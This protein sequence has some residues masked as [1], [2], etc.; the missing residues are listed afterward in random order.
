LRA[1]CKN[2]ELKFKSMN[3]KNYEINDKSDCFVI[4]EIG[5]NHQ[6]N[7]EVC[8]KMFKAAKECGVDA[9]KLQKRDNRFL[10]TK[11]FYDSAYSSENAYGPTYGLHREALEFGEAEYQELKKYA[12]ELGLIFF[13]TAFDFRSADFLAEMDMPCFKIASGDLTNIPLLKYVASFGKPMIIS[14][15]AATMEDVERAYNAI[16]LT[17][18][19]I[20]LLQCTATYPTDPAYLDLAVINTYKNKFP[21]TV[22]GLSDHYN[23]I[24]LGLVA[25]TLGARI[26]E[27]HFT[28]D[29][30][31]RGTDHA[32]SLEPVG[33]KKL[34]RDLKRARL[35]MGDGNKKIYEEERSARKKMG[36]K[37][38]VARNLPEGHV[39]GEADLAFKSPGD[40]LPP[41]YAESFYGKTLKRA[42]NEEDDLNFDC[43]I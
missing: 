22:I 8:K 13:A 24:A 33:M 25:F 43:V 19:N 6:G 11:S 42:L 40:G 37:I 7:L 30:T 27:K 14:S 15:G 4:A 34:V 39:L 35:A 12:E 28:L 36:K 9:V 17:N 3:I 10:Y 38:V 21:E 26:I 32:F 5:N 23:G 31:M 20:A 2:A 16:A 1:K 29:R 18:K 41:Y